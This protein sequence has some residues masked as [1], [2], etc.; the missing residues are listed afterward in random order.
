MVSS[1]LF[2]GEAEKPHIAPGPAQSGALGS[3]SGAGGM[4]LWRFMRQTQAMTRVIVSFQKQVK[5]PLLLKSF[6]SGP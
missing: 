5:L 4:K 1:A 3:G 6:Q 2:A